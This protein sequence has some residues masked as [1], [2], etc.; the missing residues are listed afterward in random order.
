M[1]SV[2]LCLQLLGASPPDPHRGSAPGPGWGAS[3][4]QIPV[5]SPPVAN[6]WLC[7]CE[8]SSTVSVFLSATDTSTTVTL[9]GMKFWVP[10]SYSPFW[11]RY[12]QGIPKIHTHLHS[13]PPLILIVLSTLDR[14]IQSATE[15]LP[16][17]RGPAGVLHRLSHNK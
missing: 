1:H 16:L 4:P 11:K 2:I 3:V 6:F 13:T 17:N 5:L 10:D 9:I 14:G 12:P 8:I 7:P 15:M